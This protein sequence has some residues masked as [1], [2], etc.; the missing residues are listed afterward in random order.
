[1]N[2]VRTENIYKLK[3]MKLTFKTVL[4]F[5]AVLLFIN[6]RNVMA[7]DTESMNK[8]ESARIAL[9][10]QRLGLTPEQAEKFWPLYNE[11][12]Q[13]R[14]EL[15]QGLQAERQKV[16]MNNLTEEQSQRLMDLAM[17]IK[18]RQLDLE[19]AYSQRMQLIIT[20]QQVMALRK[21]EEDFRKMIIDRLQER[22]MQQTRREQ[23]MQRRGN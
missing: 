15:Q 7:Q 16:D 23:M 10:T 5:I 9:I 2:S 4:S 8:I 14:K 13:K 6:L 1:M 20:A 18:Q 17:E 3:P 21:A 12:I 22:R 11:F 19:K